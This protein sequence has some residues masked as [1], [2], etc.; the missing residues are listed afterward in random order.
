MR[1]FSPREA[2]RMMQKMGVRIEEV[3][4]ARQVVIKTP[5]KEIV[6]DD[7]EVAV[8]EMRGQRV[9]QVT[10]GQVTE[11]RVEEEGVTIPEE[12]VQ[13]VAQQA[14]ASLEEARK[15]LEQTEGDLAQAILIL[16]SRGR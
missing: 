5:S 1:R 6:I 15:A 11:R 9:F 4:G 10:G 13:L 2:R 3:P 12:D 16:T 14:S 8:M 7:P